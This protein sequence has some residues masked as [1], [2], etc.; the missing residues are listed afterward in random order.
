MGIWI[1]LVSV[2]I[3]L[4]GAAILTWLSDRFPDKIITI[5]IATLCIGCAGGT[6]SGAIIEKNK[7]VDYEV[8]KIVHYQAYNEPE[9]NQVWLKDEDGKYFYLYL[10]DKEFFTYRVQKDNYTV[11]LELTEKQLDELRK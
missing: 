9:I 6:I 8:Y 5:L 1:I 3:A 10:S 2:V 4:L 7:K 11:A